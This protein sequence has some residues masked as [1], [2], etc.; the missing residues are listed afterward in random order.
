MPLLDD[1]HDPAGLRLDDD[2]LLSH[3]DVAIFRI[4]G[5]F[6]D[7]DIRR[8]RDTHLHRFLDDHPFRR[9]RG[10]LDVGYHLGRR[11][12]DHAARHATHHCADT[13][14]DRAADDGAGGRAS[15]HA[16]DGAIRKGRAGYA[17]DCRCENNAFHAVLLFHR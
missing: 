13:S 7:H 14:S 2:A 11:R 5:D 16:G 17:G 6:T 10:L 8:Q 3:H 1:L 12:I 15:D 9:G 4:V